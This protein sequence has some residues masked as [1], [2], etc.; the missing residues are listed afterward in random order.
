[1]KKR[2]EELDD[3]IKEVL[4]KTPKESKDT[5]FYI[6]SESEDELSAHNTTG[7][8]GSALRLAESIA[9]Y[10]NQGDNGV[11]LIFLATSMFIARHP[12]QEGEFK[13]ILKQTTML[14]GLA[15]I[16]GIGK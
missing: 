6:R 4:D 11:K 3:L 15:G 9:E 2:L 13:E 8:R 5:V 7:V 14:T 16:A 10:M 12:E 1:M